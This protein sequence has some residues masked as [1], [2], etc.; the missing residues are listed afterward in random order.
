MWQEHSDLSKG[1][2][3]LQVLSRSD[4]SVTLHE[5]EHLHLTALHISYFLNVTWS[6]MRFE[7]GVCLSVAT[8]LPLQ[9]R[10]LR[11][12]LPPHSMCSLHRHEA[13]QINPPGSKLIMQIRL[14]V[15]CLLLD[16]SHWMQSPNTSCC[17]K[18]RGLRGQRA[19]PGSH[20]ESGRS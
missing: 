8:S 4:F 5:D 10:E 7:M 2:Q 19:Y 12:P 11:L 3:W 6:E 18:D 13:S 14:Q 17:T 16:A 15:S 1:S 9:N 20:S